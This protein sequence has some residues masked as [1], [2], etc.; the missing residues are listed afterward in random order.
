MSTSLLLLELQ[1]AGPG[2]H[3]F[4]LRSHDPSGGGVDDGI[5]L[6]TF[7]LVS[8]LESEV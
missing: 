5:G 4:G 6:D 3:D 2:S 7:S 8:E 1:W